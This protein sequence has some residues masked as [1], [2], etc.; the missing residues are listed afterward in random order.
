LAALAGGDVPGARDAGLE[1]DG[2][3]SQLS[4]LLGV[5]QPGDPAFN[6]VLP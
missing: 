6:I 2:D 1:L 5:L 4:Q 3:E